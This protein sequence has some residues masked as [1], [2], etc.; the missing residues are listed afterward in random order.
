MATTP[1]VTVFV[2]HKPQCPRAGEEFHKNCK[3][4]KHLRWSYGG[5]QFRQ[6]AKTKSW[7]EAEKEK[8][9]I[10][11]KFD[12]KRPDAA[13][14]VNRETRKTT[15]N[16]ID[17][18]VASKQSQGVSEVVINKYTRELNRLEEH[19]AARGKVFPS[20]I[21]LDDLIEFRA[22]WVKAYP[23]ATT[24]QK[25][26]ERLRGFL[27][28]CYEAGHIARIPTLS[29]IKP[30]APSTMPLT[31]KE[32]KTLLE[33]VPKAFSDPKKSARVRA[34]IRLMRHSGLAIR[35]AVTLERSEILH[36]EK[37][38][39]H[40]IVTA[41]Q[42]TGTHVSVPLVPDVAT[43]L[44]AVLNGNPRFVF[45]SGNGRPESALKTW[46][47]DLRKLFDKAGMPKGHSHQLRDTFAVDMLAK[48]LPLQEVSRL[49]GHES[50]KTTE[51]YYAKWV[52]ERQDRLD[53]LV[54]A[55]FADTQ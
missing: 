37:K 6:S 7:E 16:A 42:K 5:K 34:L 49:L 27:R 4:R 35:D 12:P 23:S 52:P 39:L 13:L 21:T 22:G 32:Y 20:E 45:W 9:R 30:N 38:K 2:R 46:H 15:R 31:A 50:I 10:E 43:E 3:C 51:R 54:V 36:D 29:P 19:F 55:T 48:G 28:Y 24:R 47:D 26:Q 40:R 18:F 8:R 41:R 53:S 44:L 11:D 33:S 17:T 1:V 25:V 14:T